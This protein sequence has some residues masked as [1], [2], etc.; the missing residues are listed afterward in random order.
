MLSDN[1]MKRIKNNDRLAR[2]E[3]DDNRSKVETE[4]E[5]EKESL[6]RSARL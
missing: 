5:Q 4:T 6:E 2:E 3:R 1:E